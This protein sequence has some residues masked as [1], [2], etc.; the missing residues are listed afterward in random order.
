MTDACLGF[1]ILLKAVCLAIV[2]R[3]SQSKTPLVMQL[4]ASVNAK[5]L[6]SE[7]TTAAGV[8]TNVHRMLL[9]RLLLVPCAVSFATRIGTTI[10]PKKPGLF[11]I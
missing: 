9:A 8:V 3:I 2:V 11:Q 5:E 1:T 10:F 7:E 4:L 6:T